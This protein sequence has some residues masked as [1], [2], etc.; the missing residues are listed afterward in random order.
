MDPFGHIGGDSWSILEELGNVAGLYIATPSF[1]I[2]WTGERFRVLGSGLSR[3]TGVA[4]R[5]RTACPF[6][7]S[8]LEREAVLPVN[9]QSEPPSDRVLI[10]DCFSWVIDEPVSD[11]LRMGSRLQV[12]NDEIVSLRERRVHACELFS[13]GERASDVRVDNQDG[14]L[15]APMLASFSADRRFRKMGGRGSR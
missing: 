11:L 12:A 3:V 8:S 2:S 10:V 9:S 14:D 1:F 6:T 15:E 5:N 4:S 13:R 7:E